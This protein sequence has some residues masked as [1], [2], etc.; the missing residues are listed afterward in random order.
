MKPPLSIIPPQIAS[1]ADYEAYARERVADDAWAYLNSGGADGATARENVAAYSRIRLRPR[2]LRPLR[3]GHTR[4]TLH[5]QEYDHPVFIAP[6]AY[7]QL[8]HTD[9][10]RATALAAAA[11]RTPMVMSAQSGTRI[12]DISAS[13][14]PPLLWFQLYAQA[15]REDTLALAKRAQA[16]GARALMLTVDAPVNGARNAEQRMGFRLP[17]HISAVNLAGFAPPSLRPAHPGG[18]PLFDTGLL[19]AA[20]TWD[21]V[22]WLAQRLELPLWIKGILDPHDALHAAECGAAGI[23]VSNH[24]GRCLDTVPAT[25]DALPEVAAA[26]RGRLP[27]L[28]DGGIRRGTDVLKALALGAR[29]VMIG[30]PILH[31]LATAGAPGV[32]HAIQLLRGELEVA[33]A[34]TG[35]RTLADISSDVIWD[36]GQP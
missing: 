3:D 18:S 4:F 21:D 13:A 33:M 9:G 25:I 2:V 8:A 10:E 5:G 11:T 17:D 12:E 1:V 23:V 15:R 30:R 29:A 7:H 14:Q 26:V 32:A 24:G 36:A 35:C 16:C 31:A 34:L 28:L 6:T 22:A 19:D 20:P 27:I